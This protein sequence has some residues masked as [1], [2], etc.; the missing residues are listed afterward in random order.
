MLRLLWL[1][2]AHF[3]LDLG[4]GWCLVRPRHP[5]PWN[6]LT[7]SQI[8]SLLVR[9]SGS[10]PRFYRSKKCFT[11]QKNFS[12][13]LWATANPTA[14][15][16]VQDY[17]SKLANNVTNFGV[18]LDHDQTRQCYIVLRY[19]HRQI[20]HIFGSFLVVVLWIISI[21][22]YIDSIPQFLRN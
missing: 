15:L 2:I 13:Y 6:V 14:S 22:H 12:L 9:V 21:C 17:L 16:K 20:M 19:L 5:S 4:H 7:H 11:V 1:V 8:L 10:R 18:T 3:I